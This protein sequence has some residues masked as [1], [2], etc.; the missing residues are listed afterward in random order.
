MYKLML[1]SCFI[2][3]TLHFSVILLTLTV[4][5]KI[6]CIFHTKNEWDS[7]H[8]MSVTANVHTVTLKDPYPVKNI[9][10]TR[11]DVLA[12]QIFPATC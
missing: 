3:I 4:I 2:Q 9:E 11:I 1:M 6:I 8:F 5:F 10:Q 12:R 7:S